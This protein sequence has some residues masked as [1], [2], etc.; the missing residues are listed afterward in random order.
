MKIAVITDDGQTISKHFGQAKFYQVL[1][2]EGGKIVGRELRHKIGHS[3]GHDHEHGE[4]A[5]GVHHGMGP[6]SHNKHLEMLESISDCEA[7]ICGGMGRGAYQS[8]Q[9]KGIKPLVTEMHQVDQ[10]AL[11]YAGGTL[12]DR[13]NLLH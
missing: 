11:A 13:V 8:M 4:D 12:V 2:I 7:V 10:A 6:D 9:V 3:H 5:P 1:T